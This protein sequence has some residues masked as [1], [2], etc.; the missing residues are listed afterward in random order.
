MAHCP[1]AGVNEYDIVPNVEASIVA[2]FQVPVTVVGVLD[3]VVGNDGAE[4]P[5][6]I[7]PIG[8]NVVVITGFIVIV[9]VLELATLHNA[10]LAATE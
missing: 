8:E 1:K 4:S 7:G 3:E 10:G 2:G 6:H 5:W 9:A